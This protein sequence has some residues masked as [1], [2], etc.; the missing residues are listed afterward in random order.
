MLKW[1]KKIRSELLNLED[2]D[3]EKATEYLQKVKSLK[4]KI[5]YCV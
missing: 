1:I 3:Y 5:D 2:V 4:T